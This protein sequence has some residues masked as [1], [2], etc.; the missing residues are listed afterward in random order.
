M[1]NA[2]QAAADSVTSQLLLEQ[3]D[4]PPVRDVGK[5][6]LDNGAW[7]VSNPVRWQQVEQPGC[8]VDQ[9]VFEH[10]FTMAS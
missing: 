5:G 7:R 1:H 6:L 8:C 9:G 10:G 4:S 3:V 2:M